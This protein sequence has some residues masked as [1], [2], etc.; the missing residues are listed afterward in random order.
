MAVSLETDAYIN[1]LRHYISRRGQV[2]QLIS[3]NGTNFIGAD[4]ELREAI[5]VL[6]QQRIGGVLSRDGIRWSFNPPAG[7][8][9][10]G[11]WER[12]IRMV[13]R[14]LNSVLRQQTLDD[15]ALYK[16]FCEAEAILNDRPLT[17][18]SDDPTDLEP[19]T[20]NDLLLLKGKPV[21]PPGVFEPHD[22]YVRRRWR[23][24]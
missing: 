16:V 21:M 10:G 1:A 11:I 2:T 3:D 18:L 15:D 19:L 6:N 13:R 4:R 9:H 5:G 20:P 12:M 14:V 8:H 22:Q 23:A 17:K 24:I 7:S